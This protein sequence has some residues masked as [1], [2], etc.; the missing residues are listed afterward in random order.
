MKNPMVF[1]LGAHSVPSSGQGRQDGR[2]L[3]IL[4][5]QATQGP[6]EGK[7]HPMRPL[8]ENAAVPLEGESALGNE[9][10]RG[11]VTFSE[12]PGWELQVASTS[13]T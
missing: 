8:A 12:A 1:L 11:A 2:T 6:S 3:C 4:K 10:P 7:L 5:G 13:L 9:M